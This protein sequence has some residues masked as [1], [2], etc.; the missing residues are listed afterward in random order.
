MELNK[1]PKV[2][3][4]IASVILAFAMWLFVNGSSDVDLSID[5]IPVEFVN[6]ESALAN[7][8]LVLI[9]GDDA[10]VDLVLTMPRSLVYSFDSEHLHLYANLNSINST[11]TQS[12]AYSI[13][14]PPGVNPNQISVKSPTVQTVSVR[15]GELFRKTDVEI[16]VNLAGNVADGYVA[17]RVQARHAGG[18]GP[19]ER[20]RAGQLRAG[21]AEH[22]QRELDHR[23][24]AGVH[25]LRL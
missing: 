1:M 15:V 21:D 16:R 4:I 14:Y 17:G 25:A 13:A 9:S 22:R 10:A 2:V 23:G 12:I 8:G 20:R 11:G 7:K 6:A 3:Y 19:A 18:V 24:A 5:D